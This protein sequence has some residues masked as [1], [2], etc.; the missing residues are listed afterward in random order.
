MVTSLIPFLFP[1]TSF[2]FF[3]DAAKSWGR[4]FQEYKKGSTFGHRSNNHLQTLHNNTH[5][6]SP[7][8]EP[9]QAHRTS[10]SQEAPPRHL[11]KNLYGTPTRQVH[12][13]CWQSLFANSRTGVT[14]QLTLKSMFILTVVTLL[15][16][17]VFFFTTMVRPAIFA[18]VAA[19]LFG[20]LTVDAISCWDQRSSGGVWCAA[21]TDVPCPDGFRPVYYDNPF[22]CSEGQRCCVQ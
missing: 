2:P 8:H 9:L 16:I 21:S 19:L 20:T 17:H 5:S 10:T 18:F 1:D 14:I 6:P 4:G 22:P 12:K 15:R 11:A 3:L 13:Q 7:T